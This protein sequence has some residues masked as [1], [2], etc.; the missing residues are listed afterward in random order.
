MLAWLWRLLVGTKAWKAM[1][2]E[3]NRYIIATREVH[4]IEY[5]RQVLLENGLV[6][7]EEPINTTMTYQPY[8]QWIPCAAPPEALQLIEKAEPTY[9]LWEH[10]LWEKDESGNLRRKRSE[11]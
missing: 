5:G 1:G 3:D 11:K 6:L 10:H 9:H 4:G 2:D 8:T 7:P